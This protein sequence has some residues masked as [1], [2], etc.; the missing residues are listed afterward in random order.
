MSVSLNVISLP[1]LIQPEHGRMQTAFDRANRNR[2]RIGSLSVLQS[3]EIHQTNDRT[4][5]IWKCFN[6]RANPLLT[7]ARRDDINRVR[8]VTT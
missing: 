6:L 1:R 3:L 5:M 7:L 2:E 8:I 4:Q